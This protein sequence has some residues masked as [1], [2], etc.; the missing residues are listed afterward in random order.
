MNQNKLIIAVAG[1][2]KTTH[3][4]TE[5]LKVK[6]ENILITTYTEENE[7]EIRR[8]IT[9]KNGNIPPNITVQTWFS[10]L[11]QHGVRPYQGSMNDGLFGK[12]I[13]FYLSSEI[14][15][16]KN[17]N[18]KKKE[19]PIYW[20]E[21]DFPQYY[22]TEGWKIYSD[23]ISKFI[24]K[25][26]DKTGGKVIDRISRI[27]QHIFIDE[28][29]D[30]AGWDLEVIKIL[31]GTQSRILLVGD[32]R[33]VAYLTSH[34]RKNIKYKNGKIKEFIETECCAFGCVID[35][36]TLNRT[37]RNNQSICDFS[38]KLFPPP[39]YESSTPCICAKCR[40][41]VTDHEG[42][43]LV[44]SDDECD[45]INTHSPQ[46]LKLKLSEYPAI[47][48]G[49]SKGLTFD[50]VLIYP[51]DDIKKWIKDHENQLKDT[52]RCKFYIAITRA[53]HSVGII[54]DY[55]ENDE[56]EDVEK[57][58]KVRRQRELL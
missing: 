38:S 20:G 1:S 9:E 4:I 43:F 54:Y 58:N 29:Q 7:Q 48:Y 18:R 15:A 52:T 10:F 17:R 21:N 45:Y 40:K 36:E 33:Q 42:V 56:F 50:K 22:F 3:L 26:N 35:Q 41:H 12:R 57:W 8:K 31:L 27:Y 2:G 53:R 25:C 39:Q 14:S 47:N 34:A 5:A 24:L 30:L 49:K 55:A 51:T 19:K 32:P 6:K 28:V 23:K 46:I 37:H 11:L 16:C 44:R 13:G